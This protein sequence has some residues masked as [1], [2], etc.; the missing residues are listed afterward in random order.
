MK[1]SVGEC[2]IE[3]RGLMNGYKKIC[4]YNWFIGVKRTEYNTFKVL[5]GEQVNEYDTYED[6]CNA[7]GRAVMHSLT[8]EGL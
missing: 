4:D 8:C 6:A 2:S 1:I 5:Y 7:L 3:Q